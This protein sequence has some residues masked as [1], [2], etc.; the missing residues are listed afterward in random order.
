[1]SCSNHERNA[2]VPGRGRILAE[3][4]LNGGQLV[5]RV[6][7]LLSV[8][9]AP[10]L[11]QAADYSAWTYYRVLTDSNAT[12]VTDHVVRVVLNSGNFDFTHAETDGADIRFHDGSEELGHWI[13]KWDSGGESAEVYVR[14]VDIS[15]GLTMYYGNASAKNLSD[16]WATANWSERP[17]GAN[18]AVP[19]SM[20][21]TTAGGITLNATNNSTVSTT[22][23]MGGAPPSWATVT[24]TFITRSRSG[25]EFY[26]VRV[27]HQRD[28]FYA[29]GR[30]W[31]FYLVDTGAVPDDIQFQTST[32]DGATW[33]SATSTG[34]NNPTA[35]DAQWTVCYDPDLDVLVMTHNI[36]QDTGFPHQGLKFRQGTPETDG[37][38]TWDAAWQ[39]AVATGNMVGDY[40]VEIDTNGNT[41]VGYYARGDGEA[42]TVGDGFVIKNANTD[43]TWSTASGFPVQLTTSDDARF[44]MLSAL[45]SGGMHALVYK[46]AADV[47]ATGYYSSDGSS[48]FSSEGD[49]T[50]K[51]VEASSGTNA[52]VG[53]I[54]CASKSGVLHYVY[55]AS[56]QTINYGSRSTGGVYATEFQ[57]APARTGKDDMSSPRISFSGNDIIVLW[58]N[59]NDGRHHMRRYNSTTQTWE[60][61]RII[62][63]NVDELPE[64]TF[65]HLNP[66]KYANNE[67][68]HFV[69]LSRTYDVIGVM[70]DIAEEADSSSNQSIWVRKDTTSSATHAI[71]V[72]DTTPPGFGAN[73]LFECDLWL[74][75][76]STNNDGDSNDNLSVML[77]FDSTLTTQGPSISVYGANNGSGSGPSI[78]YVGPSF[79][80]NKDTNI[81]TGQWYKVGAKILNDT[82]YDLLLDDS[83]IQSAATQPNSL[84]TKGGWRTAAVSRHTGDMHVAN[85]RVIP[86]V[87]TEPSISVG[88]EQS[89]SSGGL[90]RTIILLSQFDRIHKQQ[91]HL[92]RYGVY[93]ITP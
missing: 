57:I 36:Q 45:P 10:S 24:K 2:E 53:R 39:T 52:Q 63:E 31:Q 44:P 35:V 6:L 89:S 56:D 90:L 40:S 4:G 91:S 16:L 13:R 62:Y 3:R 37:T 80:H 55:Q 30:W 28:C 87:A 79:S 59:G 66:A 51:A 50:T 41:W 75:S 7:I 54:D 77:L 86:W 81:N 49:V 92:D 33:S 88:A 19:T 83:T 15:R 1:M 8:F 27:P 68:L 61:Q 69:Y 93:S 72:N 64:F 12:S 23:G 82:T 65:E 67:K 34:A 71:N 78:G 38:I 70:V 32:D 22:R 76:V 58:T 42:A 5:L 60:A 46:W 73:Y 11:A 21:Q 18:D 48:T 25:Q 74:T 20:T 9:L 84:A 43:G 85:F 17:R 14:V 29:K 47:D 26:G